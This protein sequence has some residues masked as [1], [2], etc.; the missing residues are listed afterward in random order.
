VIVRKGTTSECGIV[1]ERDMVENRVQLDRSRRR[2][3]G[4]KVDGATILEGAVV[5]EGDLAQH[6]ADD[7]RD[8]SGPDVH[9]TATWFRGVAAE[10]DAAQ[11][12]AG[13]GVSGCETVHR[14]TLAAFVAGE[15]D[16]H[17]AGAAVVE[18]ARAV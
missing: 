9:R 5:A 10:G 7:R 8:A 14:S 6:R 2:A 4:F 18:V 16:I 1:R 3:G 17:E 15:A 11:L 13:G 12:R